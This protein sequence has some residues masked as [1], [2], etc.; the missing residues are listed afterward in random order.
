MGVE[1]SSPKTPEL[2][3]VKVDPPTSSGESFFAAGADGQIGD[4][5]RESSEAALLGLANDGHDQSPFES[6]SD[7]EI[8]VLVVA[9]GEAAAPLS[10]EALTTG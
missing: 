8:D 2:V 5:A 7:A 10:S 9:D 1:N 6:D 3:R 4:G